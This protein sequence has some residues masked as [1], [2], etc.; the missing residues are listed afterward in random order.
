[1]PTTTI[2]TNQ[3]AH[4]AQLANLTLSDAEQGQFAHSFTDILAV[5][6]TLKKLDT[7]GV[8]PTHQVTNLE[9]VLREDVVDETNQFT[10][11]QALAN[12]TQTHNGYFVVERILHNE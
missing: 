8:E 2:T 9:N 4:I 12:A 6:E 7:E 1:M 5:I 10:Q 3:V 11:T